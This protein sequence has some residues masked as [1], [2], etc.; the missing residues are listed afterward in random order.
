MQTI[1]GGG[2]FLYKW[3][4]RKKSH[5]K[6]RTQI[7]SRILRRPEEN[8]YICNLEV[9]QIGTFNRF[10]RYYF[11]DLYGQFCS[12]CDERFTLLIIMD[13]SNQSICILR[14]LDDILYFPNYTFCSLN[15]Y[16]IFIRPSKM[17]S[18]KLTN[19]I[20]QMYRRLENIVEY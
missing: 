8:Y 19:I 4:L 18:E 20:N 3:L 12:F 16:T 11:R 1:L 13:I 10:T 5:F 14:A 6:S 2:F 17:V 7:L 9:F 15:K